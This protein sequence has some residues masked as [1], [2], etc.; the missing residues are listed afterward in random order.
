MEPQCRRQL[1]LR[2]AIKH[3]QSSKATE[4]ALKEAGHN[5][6]SRCTPSE[7]EAM[8]SELPSWLD[9]DCLEFFCWPVLVCMK[10]R[11]P[12]QMRPPMP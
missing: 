3:G 1:K 4:A 9:D 5:I 6:L 12:G 7:K 2:L 10:R 11:L 8:E